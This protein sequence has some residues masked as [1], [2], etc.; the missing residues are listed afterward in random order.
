M[1]AKDILQAMNDVDTDLVQMP[2]KSK[3]WMGWTAAAVAACLTVVLTV[4]FFN[5]PPKA[6]DVPTTPVQLGGIVRDYA[7]GFVEQSAYPMFPWEYKTVWEQYTA[8]D[9]NG[10]PYHSRAHAISESKLGEDLGQWTVKGYDWYTETQPE[11]TAQVR[12]ITGVDKNRL[13]AVQLDGQWYVFLYDRD[14]KPATFGAFM[15]ELN[16]AQNLSLTHFSTTD[17]DYYSVESDSTLWAILSTCR[18][19]K[20]TEDSDYLSKRE[21]ISFTATSEELGISNLVFTVT[22]DGFVKTNILNFGCDYFIGQDAAKQILDYA[23]INKQPATWDITYW[24]A[25]TVTEIGDGYILVNDSVMMENPEDGMVFRI[26]TEDVR[27]RRWVEW[28]GAGIKV[29]NFV[30]VRYNDGVDTENNNNVLGAYSINKAK[31]ADG[32]VLIPG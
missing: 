27:I 24:I 6:P 12:A 31:L 22:A 32:T 20:L 29:G 11:R 16:L 13:V 17:D 25:G 9:L 2:A 26:S 4:L 1:K 7:N 3:K 15:D 30:V 18:N 8:L 5:Q 14:Q 28:I 19:A 10:V 23:H 21:H